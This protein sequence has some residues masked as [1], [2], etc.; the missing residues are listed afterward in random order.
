M[1]S[2]LDHIVK[3]APLLNDA[4]AASSVVKQEEEA[5][6]GGVINLPSSSSNLTSSTSDHLSTLPTSPPQIYLNLLI[7]EAALRSQYIVLR[8]K[9]RQ[10]TFFLLLLAIWVTY[11]FYAL[12]LR[13][14]EDGLG[15]GGS[16]Y[17][18]VEL[19]ERLALMGGVVTGILVWGTGQWEQGIRWPRKWLGITNRGLRAF[20]S[21]LVIIKGPLWRETLSTIAFLFPFPSPFGESKITP[22]QIHSYNADL[23]AHRRRSV[24]SRDP[25]AARRQE[26]LD[27][28]LSAE[29]TDLSHSGNQVKLLL[30]PK[31]FSPDFRENWELY[32]TEYWE[33]E[34]DR[35]ARVRLSIHAREKELAKQQGTQGSWLNWRTWL[36][37]SPP[38]YQSSTPSA[39]RPSV[40]H[41]NASDERHGH[42]H[43]SST[44]TRLREGERRQSLRSSAHTR[45][46]SSRSNTP[47]DFPDDR[48][49]VSTTSSSSDR[50]RRG[51]STSST[52][53][54]GIAS[55]DGATT[56]RKKVRSQS[57]QTGLRSR[58]SAS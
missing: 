13:P 57:S 40:A 22:Q 43:S 34:N 4:I 52:S 35:R 47:T 32:R 46:A 37:L 10:Y 30:L 2:K 55:S 26:E 25:A 3:G 38:S 53:A 14:R 8:A 17:W 21:K 48:S 16:V 7:L 15:V 28:L 49:T 24:R 45:T 20:N 44:T 33:K 12:F 6:H 51:A 50:T 31:A 41:H 18:A 42:S 9:R 29:E 23:I 58:M 56:R 54:S 27:P 1:A 39:R 5:P 36:G 11:F 19:G